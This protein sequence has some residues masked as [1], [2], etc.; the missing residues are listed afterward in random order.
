MA[1]SALAS[2]TS[3]EAD[4][5]HDA[6]TISFACE[7][8]GRIFESYDDACEHEVACQ[9]TGVAAQI[10][11]DLPAGSVTIGRISGRALP[12]TLGLFMHSSHE[13]QQQEEIA[14]QQERDMVHAVS[15]LQRVQRGRMARL[16]ANQHRHQRRC[17]REQAV[18]LRVA[19]AAVQRCVEKEQQA[20]KRKA[21]TVLL[22]RAAR[23]HLARVHFAELRRDR[24]ESTVCQ[25]K[26]LATHVPME[27]AEALVAALQTYPGYCNHISV[28][29]KRTS[30]LRWKT[31]TF[32]VDGIF[33]L[34]EVEQIAQMLD[35]VF[36]NPD[37]GILQEF[38]SG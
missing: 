3:S 8:C 7:N 4:N 27:T 36:R 38:Y 14:C 15:L 10:Q 2:S 25:V 6:D 18:L 19:K 23:R 34:R 24:L 5:W 29:L 9:E 37:S 30:L 11:E 31:C 13:K 17:N 1:T 35:E 26:V 28:S 32:E 20:A 33:S 21:A 12:G 16:R 22:Q